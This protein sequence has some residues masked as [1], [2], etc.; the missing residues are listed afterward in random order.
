MRLRYCVSC[1]ISFYLPTK[2]VLCIMQG[3]KEHF[4]VLGWLESLVYLPTMGLCIMYHVIVKNTLVILGVKEFSLYLPTKYVLYI[5]YHVMINHYYYREARSLVC[6][7]L[8]SFSYVSCIMKREKNIF[9]LRWV[10][11]LFCP[12][13]PNMSYVSCI[14]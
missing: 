1:N 7:Y 6:T 11:S 13:L 4:F 9:F 14:I 8:P 12:Y 3:N 2:F 10:E 5:M